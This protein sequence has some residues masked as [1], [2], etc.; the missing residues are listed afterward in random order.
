MHFLSLR[1][2]SHA[3]QEIR[4]YADAMFELIEPICPVAMEAYC[5][6]RRDGAFL[7]GPEIESLRSGEPL[8]VGNKREQAEW[9]AKRERLGL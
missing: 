3:Q 7:T 5:D 8:N 9:D 1:M 2:D 6:Y 4:V